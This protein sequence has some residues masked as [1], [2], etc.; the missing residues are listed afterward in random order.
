MVTKPVVLKNALEREVLVASCKIFLIR[1]L[2]PAYY[3][4]VSTFLLGLAFLIARITHDPLARVAHL[5]RLHGLCQQKH[6]PASARV[7]PIGL[8]G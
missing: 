3:Y 1:A 4:P 5:K 7:H 2:F 6:S 8:I